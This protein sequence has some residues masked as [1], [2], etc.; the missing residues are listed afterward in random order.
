MEQL[1]LIYRVARIANVSAETHDAVLKA[2]QELAKILQPE[3][4]K[5]EPKK[6]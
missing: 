6:K 2:V 4:K 1:N 5:V 3:E